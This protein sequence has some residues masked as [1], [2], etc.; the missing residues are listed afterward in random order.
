MFR[1]SVSNYETIRTTTNSVEFGNFSLV[2]NAHV[3]FLIDG[4]GG[5]DYFYNKGMNTELSTIMYNAET[6]NIGGA[7]ILG[8]RRIEESS[9]VRTKREWCEQNGQREQNMAILQAE[10]M[11]LLGV[12][13]PEMNYDVRFYFTNEVWNKIQ[14]YSQEHTECKYL[15]LECPNEWVSVCLQ[16]IFG[17]THSVYNMNLVWKEINNIT[18]MDLYLILDNYFIRQLRPLGY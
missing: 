6:G 18:I 12:L 9:L 10:S 11:E 1:I 16:K 3:N 15:W 17:F 4:V 7:L 14:R 13:C 8:I 2:N 5:L